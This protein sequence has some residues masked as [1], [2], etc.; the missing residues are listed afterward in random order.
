MNKHNQNSNMFALRLKWAVTYL[1]CLMSMP[2]ALEYRKRYIFLLKKWRGRAI[3][4]MKF[5]LTSD[6]TWW[7][8]QW[9]GAGYLPCVAVARSPWPNFLAYEFPWRNQCVTLQSRFLFR[10]S[11]VWPVPITV[12]INHW[13]ASHSAFS[14]KSYFPSLDANSLPS[15]EIS[16]DSSTV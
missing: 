16:V 14:V 8:G 1:H 5:L 11:A 3:N 12:W 10:V 7:P 15:T 2:S 4:Y 6:Q 13:S 9:T